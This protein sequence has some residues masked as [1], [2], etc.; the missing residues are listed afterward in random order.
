VSVGVGEKEALQINRGFF[1]RIKT[2]M[3]FVTLKAAISADGKYA[4]GQ[5]KPVWVTGELARNYVHL[6]RSRADVLITGT[7]TVLADNPQ[8]NVRLKG[9]EDTS[10]QVVIIGNRKIP[11]SYTIHKCHPVFIT[12]SGFGGKDNQTPQQVRGDSL[13]VVLKQLAQKGTNNVLV[14]AG[15]TLAGAFINAGLVDELIIIQSQKNL[16]KSGLDYFHSLSS[17]CMT[18]G[19]RKMD[20]RIKC[21]ND[22]VLSL[23]KKVNEKNLGDD[24]IITLSHNL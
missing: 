10:P 7:G 14:E 1:K 12:G 15:S 20:S 21:E 16:G 4:A 17:S 2:G 24:K 3:P 18:R 9:L 13:E 22:S 6:L 19:S 23:F 5:G 11:K 8:L